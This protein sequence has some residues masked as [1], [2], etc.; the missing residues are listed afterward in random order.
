MQAGVYAM[1]YGSVRAVSG[2][3]H[4]MALNLYKTIYEMRVIF[5]FYESLAFNNFMRL[6]YINRL[7]VK[8]M[9]ILY[10]AL[11][12]CDKILICFEQKK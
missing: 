1:H 6:F 9:S 2:L 11:F 7:K 4:S 10:Y 8:S 5:Y 3:L 12:S